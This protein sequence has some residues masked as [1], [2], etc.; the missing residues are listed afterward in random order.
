M[1]VVDV[2]AVLLLGS[3]IARGYLMSAM[4][5]DRAFAQMASSFK[6]I[7]GLVLLEGLQVSLAFDFFLR[8]NVGI[9][10]VGIIGLAIVPSII[11]TGL[12]GGRSAFV[13]QVLLLALLWSSAGHG[14]SL[15]SRRGLA[16]G[17]GAAAILVCLFV[18]VAAARRSGA[19]ALPVG[20][21][22]RAL[23]DYVVCPV[24]GFGYMLQPGTEA[25][26]GRALAH[27]FPWV[28]NQL[29]R[30]LPGYDL[31]RGAIESTQAFLRTVDASLVTTTNTA[32]GDLQLG[33]GTFWGL[34]WAPVWGLIIGK[35]HTTAVRLDRF[36][37]TVLSCLDVLVVAWTP[38][39]YYYFT[40]WYVLT[41]LAAWVCLALGE[42]LRASPWLGLSRPVLG[43]H[44]RPVMPDSSTTSSERQ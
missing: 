3:V 24:D 13:L 12:T 4:F 40:S 37:W 25:L 43:G 20:A 42:A 18:V 6:E 36:G 1:M 11:R 8:T 41:L 39:Y 7:V 2:A 26:R 14:R 31:G 5:S 19:L 27:V 29:G 22:W 35:V 21:D 44:R 34:A 15:F 23:L 16:L 32:F 9:H 10:D 33:L 17:G 28:A 38:Q 30:F